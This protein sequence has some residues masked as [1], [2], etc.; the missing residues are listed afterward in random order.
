MS[1]TEIF[2]AGKPIPTDVSAANPKDNKC[3]KPAKKTTE[4]IRTGSRPVE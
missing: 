3:F 1:L 4:G 2:P